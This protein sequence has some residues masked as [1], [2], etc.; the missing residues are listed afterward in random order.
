[1]QSTPDTTTAN[2][3]MSP[4]EEAYIRQMTPKELKSYH[5]AKSHLTMSFDLVKS[6]GFLQWKK[7]NK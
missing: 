4:E 1:M 7:S 3:A 2:P 6:N 5:I